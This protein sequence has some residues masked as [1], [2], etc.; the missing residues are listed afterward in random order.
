MTING[1]AINAN[2]AS[3]VAADNGGGGIFNDG[4]IVDITATNGP[5]IITLNVAN[6]ASSA[7]GSGGGILNDGGTLTITGALITGNSARRAGGGI[8]V[9]TANGRDSTV[10]VTNTAI[11]GNT[12]GSLPGNGGGVH[13]SDNAGG[14]TSTFTITG[15]TVSNNSAANEGGGLWNAEGGV[16]NIDGTTISNNTASGT[17]IAEG[18]GGIFNDGGMVNITDTMG[19]VNISGNIANGGTLGSGGG[20]LN[21]GGTLIITGANI[22]GNAAVRAGGGIEATTASG[23]DSNV[24]LTNVDLTNNAVGNSPGNGG[25]VH[26]SDAAGDELS[27]FSIEGGT[28]IGNSA[29]SEGGGLWNDVGGIMTITGVMIAGNT[30]SGASANQGGG[31]VF[32]NGGDVTIESGMANTV[33]SSNV[34]NGAAGSGG[35]ILNDGGIL[36]IDE[37][38]MITMNSAVRA[39]GGIEATA[40]SRDS[41]VRVIGSTISNNTAG[42]SPGNGGGVH[43]TDPLGD[44]SSLFIIGDSTVTGNSAASEGGGLWNDADGTMFIVSTTITNNEAAGNDA[45]NGGGG[46]FNNGGLTLI[47]SIGELGASEISNNRATGTAGSGG[48]IFNDGG[49]LD[50][51]DTLISDNTANRAGGGIEVTEDSLTFLSNT[52]LNENT[53]TGAGAAPGNGGGLHITGDAGVFIL[54]GTVTGNSAAEEGGGL[55]NSGTGFLSVGVDLDHRNRDDGFEPAIFEATGPG[56]GDIQTAVDDFRDELGGGSPNLNLPGTFAFGRREINWDGAPDDVSAP[57]TFPGNFFNDPLEAGRARGVEFSTPGTGFQ[58]SADTTPTTPTP[59]EFGNIDPSYTADFAPFTAERLFTPTGSNV[60]V[61]D[62]FVAG[63]DIPATVNAFGAVFSDVDREGSTVIEYLDING[64][65]I[66]RREVLATAGDETF[67][68]TGVSF[69]DPV[70]AQVR[71]TTG[72]QALG[73][74]VLDNNGSLDLV[75]MDDFIFGEP[76]PIP[77]SDTVISNN[78]ASGASPDQGGGGIFNDGGEIFVTNTTISGNTANGLAGNGGGIH[79]RTGGEVDLNNSTISGNMAS[80]VSAGG[81]NGGGIFNE[82]ELFVIDSTVSDNTATN[83]G[84]GIWN[85]DEAEL[86]QATISGNSAGDDGGGVYTGHSSGPL[87][88]NN[89]TIT[90]NTTSEDGGGLFND[91][92]TTVTL[93]STIVAGNFGPASTPSDVD[94]TLQTTSSF[95]L[96]GNGDDQTGL[97]DGLMNNQ[98]GTAGSPID[99]LLGALG[100]NGGPTQTHLLLPG[101]PAINAGDNPFNLVADQRLAGYFREIGPQTDIGAVEFQRSITV[102]GSGDGRVAIFDSSTNEELGRFRPFGAFDGEIRVAVGDVSGDGI[103]DIVTTPGPGGGSIIQVFDGASPDLNNPTLIRFFDAYP[104]FFGGVYVAVANLNP[105]TDDNADIITGAGAT[106]GSHVRAF[107]GVFNGTSPQVLQDFFAYDNFFGGVRV[108]AG[109]ITGDGIP[110]IIT[111]AGPGGGPA[112]RVFDGSVPQLIAP[113]V[114]VSIPGF[115][116]TFHAFDPSFDGGVFVASGDIDGNGRADIIVSKGAGPSPQVTVFSGLDSQV[117]VN[118]LDDSTFTGGITVG[119]IN[120]PDLNGADD[121]LTGL[122]PGGG[123]LVRA[124]NAVGGTPTLVTFQ[125]AFEP[126][127]FGGIYVAG[128]RLTPQISAP[129]LAFGGGEVAAGNAAP[130][131]QADL[132][133]VAEAA[134]ARLGGDVPAVNFRIADLADGVLGQSLPGTVVID[135]NASGA[136]WFIDPSPLDDIEFDQDLNATELSALGRVDLLTVILH[137]L[138]HQLGGEDLSVIDHPENVLAESLTTGKRRLPNTDLDAL[139]ADG[140]ELGSVLS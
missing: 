120:G 46:V 140:E 95:N 98:L 23:R 77:S 54:G 9:T 83:E 88:V 135:I 103:L 18:G 38:T 89:S 121:I 12:A 90:D 4:G 102:V 71:I 70:I 87:S 101:S 62:F 49:K 126:T 67:S 26:I 21:D 81:G 136:G 36:L 76:V 59:V 53:A 25:G 42:S 80:G 97:T 91:G 31:G 75:V 73:L 20:I 17:D 129:I 22:D 16:M 84:G 63:T 5:T 34:A 108:A 107:S 68:F 131:T 104:G 109:D 74:G 100:D 113:N 8:E 86:D 39:G 127:F 13:I 32:N 15:G 134:I 30:A 1:T 52:M 55:W 93:Q 64:T 118:F 28:V 19:A 92:S 33:I 115:L 43:I 69:L 66:E 85:S 94:G 96:I 111:G 57:G 58:L 112:V 45:T 119:A 82:G 2:T 50:V 137:E 11:T 124:F 78:I 29:A 48:G 56:A 6:G 99:P 138:G 123:P 139:F 60:T 44:D 3:G 7:A 125:N 106:G 24:T 35:G 114:G 132:D 37:G 10:I 40:T 61:I 130:L 117:L 47:F 79:N 51:Y 110:D 116:G 72:D 122:G 41:E 14:N 133:V 65:V 128:G 27:E 105:L